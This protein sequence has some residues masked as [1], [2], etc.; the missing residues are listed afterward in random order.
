[1]MSPPAILPGCLLL[2]LLASATVTGSGHD[3]RITLYSGEFD[4]VSNSTPHPDM[5]GLALIRQTLRPELHQGSN[6]I[7]LDRLPLALD[8][9]SVQLSPERTDTQ[10]TGQRYDLPDAAPEQLLRNAIGQRIVVEQIHGNKVQRHQGT[11]LLPQGGMTLQQDNGRILNLSQYSSFELD[12]PGDTPLTLRNTLR[13]QVQSATT[14][15]QPLHL[16]YA[17]GGLAWQAEYLLRLNVNDTACSMQ[18]SGVAQVANRSGL[19]YP[20]TH[21]TLVAGRPN[22]VSAAGDHHEARYKAYASNAMLLPSSPSASMESMDVPEPETAGEYHAYPLPQR[23]DL[24]DASIQRVPLL[25][26]RQQVRCQRLY[27][28]GELIPLYSHAHYPQTSPGSGEQS[29]PITALL[30]F[31]NDNAAGLGVPL[32]AGRVRLFE[33]E[34]LLG[35]A[36]LEHSFNG[37]KAIRLALGAPFDLHGTRKWLDSRLAN[38]SLSITDT[39]KLE[40]N[41]AKPHPVTV[42]IHEPMTRWR[43]WDITRSSHPWERVNAHTIAFDVPVPAQQKV[44]LSY[45][46]RYRW[47]ASVL[48]QR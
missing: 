30:E 26:P 11:L 20:N 46:V 9:G 31:D 12:A 13:W 47:P 40:L 24:P 36:H 10:I 37:Q 35:E 18:F 21:L 15:P 48:L 5:P 14:G 2:P 23:V 38:D 8:I 33:Q 44:E 19:D 4:Q 34:S 43:D 17:T 28:A 41:N 3:T 29:L 22:Q 39:I 45:T 1:M 32:P 7:A 25:E 16:D 42:R 6:E 27:Q